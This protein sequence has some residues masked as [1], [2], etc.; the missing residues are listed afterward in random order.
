MHFIWV[1]LG[2]ALG[3]IARYA[4]TLLAGH[5]AVAS[6]WAIGLANIV[7]SFLIG[8]AMAGLKGD[9]YLFCA[10]GFCGGFTTFSTFSAQTMQLLQTGQRGW[11]LVY[12]AASVLLSLLFVSI[13]Y[14]G[15]SH[16]RQ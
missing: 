3:S 14:W 5:Y 1:G 7:G 12:M 4:L 6:E 16:W 13:G 2:G 10:M 8:L 11:A 15:G 9:G